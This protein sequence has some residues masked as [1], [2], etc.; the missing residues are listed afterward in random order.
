MLNEVCGNLF[1]VAENISLAHCVSLDLKM[2]AGIAVSFKALFGGVAELQRQIHSGKSIGDC[3]VL[4]R[5]Q[6]FIFY[7][8]T[9]RA[10]RHKPT[11]AA[12]EQTL[13]NLREACEKYSVCNLAL[14]K[15]GCGLDGLD[16]PTVRDM[17]TSAFENSNT[18]IVVYTLQ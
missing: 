4:R 6:R 15:I 8:I 3:L 18:A 9:K 13:T 1:S 16:W 14:P 12:L 10:A 11:Y 17:L 5:N 2:G 7:L